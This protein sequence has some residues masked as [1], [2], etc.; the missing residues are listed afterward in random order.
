MRWIGNDNIFCNEFRL[1][2]RYGFIVKSPNDLPSEESFIE[3]RNWKN[4]LKKIKGDLTK[5][6]R[7]NTVRDLIRRKGIP[8]RYRGQVKLLTKNTSSNITF[9]QNVYD[10]DNNNAT[11]S[12][13]G[14]Q[15]QMQET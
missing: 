8:P 14:Y 5:V 12:R 7:N 13:Y 9:N 11:N 6:E 1:R 15:L 3:D 10:D 4:Y 2:D